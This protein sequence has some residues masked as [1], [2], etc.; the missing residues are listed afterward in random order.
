MTHHPWKEDG[1][2]SYQKYKGS[3]R[4]LMKPGEKPNKP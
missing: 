2:R 3:Q 1:N 4:N